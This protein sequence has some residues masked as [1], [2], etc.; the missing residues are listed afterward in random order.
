MNEIEKREK[1]I[2][3]ILIQDKDQGEEDDHDIDNLK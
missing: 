2:M 3:E 1:K